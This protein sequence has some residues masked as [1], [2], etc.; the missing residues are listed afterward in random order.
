MILIGDFE[1]KSFDEAHYEILEMGTPGCTCTNE[2][3]KGASSKEE[4]LKHWLD[5]Y[6]VSV[7]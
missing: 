2:F 7:K 1:F 3:I 4:C 6:G 5:S